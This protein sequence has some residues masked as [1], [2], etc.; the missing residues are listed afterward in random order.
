MTEP[1]L[2][3]CDVSDIP[4]IRLILRETWLATYSAFIPA[5]DILSYFETA[6]SESQLTV[7]LHS[8]NVWNFLAVVKD[9]PMGYLRT[10]NDSMQEKFFINSIYVLPKAQGLGLGNLLLTHA[11]NQ[12][13]KDQYDKIYLGVMKQNLP[14]LRWYQKHGFTFDLEEPFQMGKT[15]VMHLIGWAPVSHL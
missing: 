5:D 6:Y 10:Q 11:R 13:E 9:E 7:L 8:T 15:Q 2:K 1:N 14:A 12:A 3:T 4:S